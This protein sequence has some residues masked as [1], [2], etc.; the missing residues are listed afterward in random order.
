MPLDMYNMRVRGDEIK[1]VITVKGNEMRRENAVPLVLVE[2]EQR[3][4]WEGQ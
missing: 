3:W 4:N 2:S 1:F